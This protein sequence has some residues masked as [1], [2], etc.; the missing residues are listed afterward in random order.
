AAAAAL[1]PAADGREVVVF[2]TDDVLALLRAARVAREMNL[3]ARYVGGEDAY[4]LVSEVTAA[5]PPP[6]LRVALP[7]PAR[8]AR[9]EEWL[10]VPLTKLRAYDRAP[11]NPKWLRDAGLE[12]SLTTDGLDDAK[13]FPARVREARER[14]LAQDDALAAV[15]TVPARQ[16]GLSDRLGTLAPGKIADLVVETGEPF[17]E[18]SRVTEIW[19][20]GARIEPR[21]EKPEKK[22]GTAAAPAPAA[23]A[24]K[25]DVRPAPAREASPVAT[26]SAVVVRGATVWTQGPAGVME[27]ADVL[28]VDGKIA[29]V[30]K[31]LAA[32]S[33]AVE[34]DGRGKHV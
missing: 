4:R 2:E 26:P 33:G 25:A 34:V 17:D 27:S 22:Q 20:D 32:P 1:G 31:G 21:P 5:Q 11:S 12:F 6:V 14:G 7:P 9:G 24:P 19:I 23:A 15:T 13:D 18:K 30:G 8:L 29:A 16:L 28:V 3:R 10:D